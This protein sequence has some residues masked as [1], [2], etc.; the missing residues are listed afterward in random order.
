MIYSCDV[1]GRLKKSLHRKMGKMRL[2]GG[3][4]AR[5]VYKIR[6]IYGN[7]KGEMG[8]NARKQEVGD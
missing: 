5:C 8:I 7:E 2:R 3:P 1:D 4:R 6:K